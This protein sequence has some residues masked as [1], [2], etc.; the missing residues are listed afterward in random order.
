MPNLRRFHRLRHFVPAFVLAAALAPVVG[1]QSPAQN[2]AD[3]ERFIRAL[4][5]KPGS[6]VAEIGAGDGELT[7]AVARAVGETG[8]LYSNELNRER[9]ESVRK[10]AADAGLTNVTGIEGREDVANLP[11]ACCDAVFMRNVY[12]HFGD[13]PSMN[14]SLLRALKP[15]G[16][17]AIVD[18][19]P[20]PPPGGENPPGHRGEDNHHGITLATLEKELKAA[21]FAIVSSTEQDREI[22]VVARRPIG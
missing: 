22:F 8:R 14:G 13:P 3:A 19:T 20:P 4:E 17:L 10:R 12:H 21:G 1:T 9:L 5:V 11:D 18:F 15:G 2:A 7:L 6:V 16:R